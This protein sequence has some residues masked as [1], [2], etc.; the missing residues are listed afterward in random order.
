M[1]NELLIPDE[2]GLITQ[3]ILLGNIE[4]AVSL[5]FLH[6]RYADAVILS[7]AGG[8]DLL[9]KTQYRYLS[10]HSSAVNS[11]INSVVSQDWSDIVKNCDVKC[12]KEALVGVLTHSCPEERSELCGEY[13][14]SE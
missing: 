7:M 10:E 11:L 9:A 12:W 8:P 3:A 1:K 14:F 5:C 4:A 2:E 6:K 13:F